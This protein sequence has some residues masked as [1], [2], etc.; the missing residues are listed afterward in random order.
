MTGIKCV[1]CVALLC[2]TGLA[3]GQSD[4]NTPVESTGQLQIEGT[5]ITRLVLKRTD[6]QGSEVL[7]DPN[8]TVSLPVGSYKIKEIR[9]KKDYVYESYR[10][11]PLDSIVIDKDRPCILSAGGPLTPSIDILREGRQ[12][13]LSYKRLGIG[14][15]IYRSE[16]I[17]SQK[18]PTFTV[19]RGKK[20]IDTGRFEYG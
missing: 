17:D 16:T 8:K 20:A 2:F 13:Q 9:L 4:A 19:Y 3:I 10:Q 15:E 14:Q 1:L 7:T 12:L 6:N 5:H 11:P 18:A